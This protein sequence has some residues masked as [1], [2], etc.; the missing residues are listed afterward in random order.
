MKDILKDES[1][2]RTVLERIMNGKENVRKKGGIKIELKHA[3]INI[4]QLG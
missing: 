1:D 2:A 4:R 3:R